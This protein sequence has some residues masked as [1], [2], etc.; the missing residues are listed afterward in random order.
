M[1]ERVVAVNLVA[2]TGAYQTQMGAASAA[3][4][5]FGASAAASAAPVGTM[6]G[7]M[8]GLAASTGLLNPMLLGAG[9]LVLGLRATIGA[10]SQWESAFAGVQKTVDGTE[11]QMAGLASGLRDLSKEIPTTANDLASIAEAAGQL[12]IQTPNILEFTRTMADLGEATNMSATDA[13]TAL[14][15]L[16]NITQ[17]SQGDFDRLGSVVVELGNNLA[18]TEREIVEMGLRLAGAGNQVGLTEAEIMALA[19]A[20]SSVGIEA[21]AG[22]TAFSKVMIEMSQAASS[23]GDK[24]EQFARVAGMSAEE[25]ATAFREDPAG[26]IVAFVEGLGHASDAGE[27]LFDILADLGIEEIRMRDA[28]LRTAGAGDVLAD[29]IGMANGAWEE[30]T[31][32]TEEAARRY[33]TL[34]SKWQMFKN[35]L[36]DISVEIGQK[37]TPALRTLL[38]HLNEEMDED[39]ILTIGDRIN[40]AARDF[41]DGTNDIIRGLFGVTSETEVTSEMVDMFVGTLG[42]ATVASGDTGAAL[43]DMGESAY[44]S[45]EGVFELNRLLD[46]LIGI[47]M[48]AEQAAIR[49][50]AGW[51]D[52]TESLKE[53]GTTLDINTEKGRANRQAILDQVSVI[54]DDIQARYDQGDSLADIAVRYGSHID[55][56]RG[57]MR[58]AGMT[59]AQIDDYIDTLGLTPEE[60]VTALI[61]EDR[62]TSIIGNVIRELGRVPTL[63]TT[64][65]RTVQETQYRS[66]GSPVAGYRASGG[67]VDA[68]RT[69]MVGEEGPELV[70]FG[71]AGYVHDADTTAA[72]SVPYSPSV[73][74]APPPSGT[75]DGAGGGIHYHITAP[76]EYG[77]PI[78]AEKLAKHLDRMTLLHA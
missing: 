21:Q 31:A 46:D 38:D 77:E 22:G 9:G 15:R 75:A 47:T 56:L 66:S 58:Q 55:Q 2:R 23:G 18:T 68:G 41:G 71:H 7:R 59:E 76:G 19:G 37:L 61:A 78:T 3:N 27:N 64:T 54:R 32:L 67:P 5:R 6:T 44:L 60:V 8:K 33:E 11:Q 73:R 30:N 17:M 51:D 70:T 40:Q 50:E 48:S 13:A 34:A 20:L 36:T 25:F 49:L 57:V 63:T 39:G 4:A 26:A 72:M 65:I 69:Y 53:N 10:A 62:A 42:D 43:E 45:S 12:G 52:L 29:A 1:A 14:A 24:L 28:L 35:N 74:S 16:A